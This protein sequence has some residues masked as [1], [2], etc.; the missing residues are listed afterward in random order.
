MSIHGLRMITVEYEGGLINEH[1]TISEFEAAARRSIAFGVCSDAGRVLYDK[2]LKRLG[3]HPIR[4][5]TFVHS[6]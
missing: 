6:R 1:A 4:V 3:L 2:I 5:A